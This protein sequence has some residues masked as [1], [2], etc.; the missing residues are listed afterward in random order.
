[1]KKIRIFIVDDHAILREGLRTIIQSVSGYEV[2][3]ESGDGRDALEKIE[4]LK[5]DVVI[6]DISLPS[7]TGVEIS[8]Q[9][10][11]F[12]PDIRI[13]ILTQ[14]NNDEYVEHLMQ[15]G[16]HGY[17]LKENTSIDLIRAISEA[18]KDNI[19][20]SPEITKKMVN[21]YI[22]NRRQNSHV[23]DKITID[24]TPRELEIVKLIAEGKSNKQIS[25]ML[26]IS[27]KTVNVHR[28]NIMKKLGIKKV[29]GLVIYAMSKGL[30]N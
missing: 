10:R 14:Y 9:L 16:V 15:Y 13:I 29:T 21:N 23:E 12:N 27:E 30:I 4:Q 19:Y 2:I 3:G 17:I 25:S 26:F 6:L 20:L 1:M 11:K 7:M 5:P 28:S 18:M 22:I 8:R 24:L